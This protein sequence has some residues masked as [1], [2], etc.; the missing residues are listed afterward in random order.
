M[1]KKSY[2]T[3]QVGRR[4]NEEEK[5]IIFE[6]SELDKYD[7][8]KEEAV[9]EGNYFSIIK[10]VES[11]YNKQH[12]PCFDVYYKLLAFKDVQAWGNGLIDERPYY[13]IKQR[14]KHGSTPARAFIQAVRK[15]GMPL[16][17]TSSQLIGYTER[18]RLAYER[19]GGLGSIIERIPDKIEPEYFTDDEIE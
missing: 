16:K 8:P 17:F 19:D 14:Y 10:A 4:A 18:I 1:E 3:M 5:E 9:P 11:S 13:Y 7:F 12:D 15:G 6:Y 2:A